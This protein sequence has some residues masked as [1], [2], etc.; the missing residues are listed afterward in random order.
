MNRLTQICGY[1]D[2]IL[3]I[4][5]SLPALE[6][7]CTELSREAGRVG[8]VVSPDK[9]KYMRFS[10]SPSRS[11]MEGGTIN[12]VTYAGVAK[13][14]YLGTLISNDNSVEKEV[15]RCILASNRTYFAAISLFRNRLLSRATK[16]RLYKTLIIT[17]VAHG[18]ETWMMTKKDE[19]ALLIFERKIFRR[20]HGPKY[21]NGEWKSR[22]NRELEELGKREYRVKWIKGQRISWLGH[23]ERMEKDRMPKKLHS[24]TEGDEK[25]GKTQKRMERRSRKRSSSD[26]GEKMERVGDREGKMEGHCSTG[27]SP[28]RAAAPMEEEEEL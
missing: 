7:L 13:F 25:K 18:A 23:L 21:E 1:S 20:I 28:Q 11:S 3:V 24:R 5:R 9:T 6:A 17:T 4:A 2:D 26:G 27:Q 19:Q 22:T 15:Q 12:G 8:L 14:I 10:V 16:T